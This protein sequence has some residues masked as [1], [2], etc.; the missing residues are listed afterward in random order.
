MTLKI[1]AGKFYLRADGKKAGPVK[2]DG[3]ESLQWNVPREGIGEHWY[4]SDG[5]SSAGSQY[6]LIA[7]WTAEPAETDKPHMTLPNGDKLFEGD[8][9]VTREGQKVGPIKASGREDAHWCVDGLGLYRADGTFGYG[10]D[11][12][13]CPP[14]DI[15]AKHNPTTWPTYTPAPWAEMPKPESPVQLPHGHALMPSGEV[16]DLTAITTPFGLLSEEVKSALAAHGGPYEIVDE[17]G[18]SEKLF[19]VFGDKYTYR[20]RPLPPEPKVEEVVLYWHNLG[21]ASKDQYKCDTHRIILT[22]RDGKPDPVA[23]VEAL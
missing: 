16:V 19:K 21:A 2:S 5:T 13:K 20:V 12:V 1:E 18:W 10:I 3:S 23:K 11:E 17:S 4:Y 7:E 9:G 15:I 6:N 8:Y 22:M 14:Y